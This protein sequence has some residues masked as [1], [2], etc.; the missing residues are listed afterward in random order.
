MYEVL[1]EL[2]RR[3]VYQ[4]LWRWSTGA[5]HK[6][7][8]GLSAPDR[9]AVANLHRGQGVLNMY[10]LLT[11]IICQMNRDP[12]LRRTICRVERP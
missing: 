9:Q 1:Y 12:L 4:G 7:S 3:Q 2:L 11:D 10:N 5:G 6:G 8:E